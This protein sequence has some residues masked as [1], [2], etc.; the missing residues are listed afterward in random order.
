MSDYPKTTECTSANAA[1][2]MPAVG[3]APIAGCP[4]IR[5]PANVS[6]EPLL[7]GCSSSAI[8]PTRVATTDVPA[9]GAR[10]LRSPRD[11]RI[12]CAATVPEPPTRVDAVALGSAIR[13]CRGRAGITQSVLST[14]TGISRQYIGEVERG[15]VNPS[16][17]VLVAIADALGRRLSALL[18]EAE[19]LALA[20]RQRAMST[21]VV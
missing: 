4:S 19:D 11:G 1:L 14:S 9:A 10:D 15:T 17:G 20:S 2:S 3:L 8:A 21:I 12:H 13:L 5:V 6:A 7:P 16:F 18:V